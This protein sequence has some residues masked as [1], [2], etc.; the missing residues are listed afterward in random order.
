MIGVYIILYYAR[1]AMQG[2]IPINYNQFIIIYRLSKSMQHAMYIHFACSTCNYSL[3][4]S[5]FSIIII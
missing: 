5:P 4:L 3:V 2:G 1:G